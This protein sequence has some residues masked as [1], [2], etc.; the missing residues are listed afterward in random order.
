[1]QQMCMATGHVTELKTLYTC[2][3]YF[4]FEYCL[5]KLLVCTW[6]HGGRVGGQEQKHFSPLVTKL[7][8]HVNSWRKNYIVFT[9]SVAALSRGCK[10]RIKRRFEII[11]LSELKALVQNKIKTKKKEK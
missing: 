6:C 1:M 7:H 3:E 5:H 9:P 2:M 10:P 8:F 11:E 4:L